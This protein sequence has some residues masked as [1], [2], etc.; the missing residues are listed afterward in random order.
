MSRHC[1]SRVSH[2]KSTVWCL[3]SIPWVL[4]VLQATAS[5]THVIAAC[6]HRFRYKKLNTQLN[7]G[8]TDQTR[9]PAHQAL[10]ILHSGDEAPS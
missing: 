6:L 10:R 9:T 5:Q 8:Q 3:H 4:G 1:H 7:G 2:F